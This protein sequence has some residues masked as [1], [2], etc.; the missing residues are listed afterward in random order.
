MS[1]PGGRP[2]VLVLRALGLGDLLTG[3]PALRALRRH[4]RD[5]EIVL[6]AP[7]RLGPA[8]RATGCADRLLP[9]R[10]TGREVPQ[11]LAWDGPPP[12][13]A[14]DLHGDGP[15]SR[16]VLAE[17]RPARLIAYA[18]AGADP[19][20]AP[21]RPEDQ[22]G[23][24]REHE[25]EHERDRWCRLLRRHHI[26]ADPADLR[27][28]RP[29]AS[30][31][32]PGAIVL[33]PGA[34]AVSR[35]WP[36]D[37]FAAVARALLRDGR[38]VVVTAGAGERARAEEVA[39]GAGLPPAAVLGGTDDLPFAVLAA[40]VA[41]ARAVVS[42][43]TGVAHLASALGAPSVTLFGPISPALWGPPADARH[44]ALW[45]PDPDGG[46]R[47]GDAHGTVPDPRL[48]RVGP[49]DVLAAL[50][51]LPAPPPDPRGSGLCTPARP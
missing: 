28:E 9:T 23:H 19:T 29:T 32:A 51:T 7:A 42:G 46:S 25:H 34:D 26:H 22:H 47:P 12:E 18:P 8:V 21:G 48:L 41:D 5:H 27:I 43:D 24:T 14:V 39:R 44:I 13:V 3:V 36:A 1:G 20:A 37:R 2:T 40:L 6:A 4:Y 30:S 11:S 49:A 10:A 16:A 45:R 31:P 35:Q 17:L 33:H 38:P 50:A 15:A